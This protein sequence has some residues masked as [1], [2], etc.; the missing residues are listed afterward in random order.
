MTRRVVLATRDRL[1]RET[2]P[3]LLKDHGVEVPATAGDGLTA[4][5]AVARSRPDA[6]LVVDDLARP[7]PAALAREAHRRWP[8]LVIVFV[9]IAPAPHAHVLGRDA[10]V[11]DVV[12]ALTK[13]PSAPRETSV[14]EKPSWIEQLESLTPRE[15]SV[16]K[17]LGAGLSMEDI[18]AR[19]GVSDHTI[20]THIGRLYAKLGCHS[21]LEVVR[22]AVR[23]GLVEAS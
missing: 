9:G 5:A 13:P 17:L 16:L 19:L 10:R 21:R 1:L 11:E 22:F 3:V 7:P 8:K 14:V 4:I 6:L 23:H 18:A 20:R 12:A 15:R 2:A